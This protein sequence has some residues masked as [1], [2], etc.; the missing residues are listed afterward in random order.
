MTRHDTLSTQ[1]QRCSFALFFELARRVVQPRHFRA[2]VA[3][4]LGPKHRDKLTLKRAP[5]EVGL[6]MS[7]PVQILSCHVRRRIAE[8]ILAD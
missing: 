1:T 2:S 4:G 5:E 6:T 3:A 7:N 8:Q